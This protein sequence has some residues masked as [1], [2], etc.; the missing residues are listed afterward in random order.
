MHIQRH[1]GLSGRIWGLLTILAALAGC[2]GSGSQAVNT[3]VASASPS[4]SGSPAIAVVANT[5]Y[6]F[7]PSV[8]N[9]TRA[10][11]TF[12][13]QNKPSWATFNSLTGELFG[14]P[15]ASDAGDFPNISISASGGRSYASLPDFSIQVTLPANTAAPSGSSSGTTSSS[16]SSSSSSSGAAPISGRGSVT[17]SWSAPTENTN[18]S[19]LTD[20]A[21]YSIYYGTSATTMTNMISI[22][23]V[24][25]LTY[26]VS[27]LTPGTWYF[28]VVAVS[29]S[30]MESNP[31]T[32]VE[33]TI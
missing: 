33:K 13:I 18:G 30:G 3:G 17:L 19:A 8:T 6:S 26:V 16:T 11:L 27:E 21:G 9:P 10:P 28:A 4:V 29:D 22:N 15:T 32:T 2:G 7:Q 24:G 5:K 12:G 23:T 20:L 25:M 14:T 1:R 31:S